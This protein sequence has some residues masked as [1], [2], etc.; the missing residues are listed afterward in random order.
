MSET[1]REEG[2]CY[3]STPKHV[4][5]FVGRFFY[6]YTD[7]G[8]LR[9][10]SESLVFTSSKNSIEIPLG[11]VTDVGTGH[12]SRIAKPIRLDS[13][14]VTSS[15]EGADETILLTP[16]DSWATPVWKTNKVVATWVSLLKESVHKH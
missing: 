13:M 6:I 2:C 11:L 10:T 5:S 3:L 8:S 15:R 12:Y 9:L 14:A 1:I 16:T 4:R 7:K